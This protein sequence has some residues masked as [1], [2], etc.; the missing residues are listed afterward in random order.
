MHRLLRAG[1][2]AGVL[3][4]AVVGFNTVARAHAYLVGCNIKNHQALTQGQLPEHLTCHFAEELSPDSWIA[5]FEG[6]ADHGLVT[7]KKSVINFKNPKVMSVQLP[8]MQP[9][10]YYMIWYTHSLQDG[11]RAAGILYFSVRK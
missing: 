10:K 9:L 1:V 11:H 6:V 3:A 4:T 7:E 5:V 2:V 8:H